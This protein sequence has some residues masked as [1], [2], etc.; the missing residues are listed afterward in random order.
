[1]ISLAFPFDA[2]VKDCL[3]REHGA[4]WDAERRVWVVHWFQRDDVVRLFHSEGY[5][6][7]L[8]EDEQVTRL[9]AP[10]KASSPAQL[11]WAQIL[12]DATPPEMRRPMFKAVMKVVHPDAG[13]D[14]RMAQDLNNAFR[15]VS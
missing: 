14:V 8:K 11:S 12:H 2:A 5:E 3:K 1:M 13:G 4:R 10:A 15:D 9:S 7:F 6:A